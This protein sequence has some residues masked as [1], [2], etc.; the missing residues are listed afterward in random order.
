MTGA[1]P[2][3]RRPRS[4]RRPAA[5][6]WIVAVLMV[7]L[8]Q[9][10]KLWAV[11]HLPAG[12]VRSLGP[13][14]RQLRQ[15][16]NTGAAF[17]L[18]TGSTLP[19]AVVSLVVAIAVAV[20]LVRRPPTKL[21]PALALGF[22]LGGAVGNGIDRWRLGAVIDFLEFVPVSF[23]VFNVADVAINLAVLCFALDTLAGLRREGSHDA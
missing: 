9:L 10:S 13:G 21:L 22:L 3:P 17:S 5:L 23:P 20:L 16:N 18:F 12:Q 15:V 6:G 2:G 8:D 19:L 1:V 7:A 14:L 11:A 4:S